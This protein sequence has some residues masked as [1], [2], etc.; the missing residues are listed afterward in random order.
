MANTSRQIDKGAKMTS[1]RVDNTP[2]WAKTTTWILAVI[3]GGLIIGSIYVGSYT[4]QTTTFYAM[5]GLGAILFVVDMALLLVY[6]TRYIE[7]NRQAFAEEET[8]RANTR[9]QI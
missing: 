8:E 3:W 9:Q 7:D 5:V 4:S 6:A 1:T 2:T